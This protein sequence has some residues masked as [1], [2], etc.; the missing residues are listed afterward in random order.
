MTYNANGGTVTPASNSIKYGDPYILPTPSRVGY[1]FNGWFTSATGGTQVTTSNKMSGNTTVYAQWTANK[2]TVNYY[3]NGATKKD[4][5]V[6][7]DGSDI[8]EITSDKCFYTDALYY[9]D[10]FR[11]WGLNNATRLIREGY[12]SNNLYHA[13]NPDSKVMLNAGDNV[14]AKTQDLAKAA[15]VLPQL[16]KGDTT[17]NIYAH[18]EP[19]TYTNQIDHWAYGFKNGDGNN[20]DKRAYHLKH[21]TF[22][23]KYGEKVTYTTNDAITIPNGFSL[24][25]N[26]GSSAYEGSWKY[27]KMGTSFSQPSKATTVEYDYVPITYTITYNLNGGTLSKENPSTYNVL[28]GVDFTNEPTKEGYKFLGWYINGKKVTGI[29]VGCNA[30][31]TSADD[32]YA[33]LATR[34][35]GDQTV[36]AK[37][38]KLK[39]LTIT[40]KVSGNMGSKD[41]EFTFI[42]HFPQVFANTTLKVQKNDGSITTIAVDADGKYSFTLKHGESF[43]FKELTEAQANAIKDLSSYGISESDYSKEGYK[44]SFKLS[45][46]VEGNLAIAYTNQNG[47]VLPTGIILSGSGMAIIVALVIVLGWVIRKTFLK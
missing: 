3:P 32:L 20:N 41:K 12:T 38:E 35:T 24:R 7:Q 15:G 42:A 13:G 17:L 2:L 23:K 37:W 6:S 18:W 1:K 30:T 11:S 29:N 16:E 46:D 8:V 43:A 44:T 40:N 4:D 27:Y 31:F 36:E 21:T 22:T 28:Y 9:G 39:D 47:T 34:T 10:T 26:F 14:Y 5:S 19:N 45:I 25:E 33:K